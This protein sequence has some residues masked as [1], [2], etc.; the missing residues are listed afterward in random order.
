[1][2]EKVFDELMGEDGLKSGDVD[3]MVVNF[4]FL[5]NDENQNQFQGDELQLE[6]TFKAEQ[7]TGEDK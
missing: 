7:E 6:W 5:D 3:D 1:M 4:N 2:K